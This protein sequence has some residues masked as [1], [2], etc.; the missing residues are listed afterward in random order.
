MSSSSSS[1]A[2]LLPRVAPPGGVTR[3]SRVDLGE[4]WPGEE[5]P[6]A[7][8]TRRREHATGRHLARLALAELGYP[9][10]VVPRGDAGMPVWPEG[11][12]GS[13][14]HCTGFRGV[15]LARAAN[16]PSLGVDAEPHAPLPEGVGYLVTTADET[17]HLHE[18][19]GQRPDLH[20]DRLLFSAK[21]AVYKAW[22]PAARRWLGFDE[23]VVT[24]TATGGWRAELLVDGPFPAVEGRWAVVD[25]VLVSC[26][27]PAP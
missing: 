12:V 15:V 5:L 2:E 11:V 27:W 22:F 6:L 25:R 23:A 3:E 8:A 14:T 21:E 16:L 9:P 7:V 1:V 10:Q 26:G 17:A 4:P 19:A 13:I 18:L 20:W 24:L